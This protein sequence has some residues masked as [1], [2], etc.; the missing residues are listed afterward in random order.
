MTQETAKK[1]EN[2]TH[3][4]GEVHLT[5]ITKIILGLTLFVFLAVCNTTVDPVGDSKPP[6][7]VPKVGSKP[8][9]PVSIRTLLDGVILPPVN[10]CKQVKDI[11]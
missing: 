10:F 6:L 11:A 3:A 5:N 9:T 7:C 1:D 4:E 2:V 8:E